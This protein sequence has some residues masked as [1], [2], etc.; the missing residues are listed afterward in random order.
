MSEFHYALGLDIGIGSVGWA[1]LRNQPNGEPDRIQDLG[2]RIFDKAEQPKTGASLAAP[3]RDARSAR[4]RL[5]R[6]RH[7]LERI[8]YLMEQRGIMPVADI[9]AMYA[10]G[11]FQ[12]SPYQLRAEALD[13]PLTKEEAV[14]VLIHLAQRRGYKSNSTAEAAKDEKE[15]GKVKTAIEENRRCMA[16]HGYRTVGE[17]MYRDE[18]FWQKHPDGTRYHQ[19]RN[20]AEDY[21]FTVERAAIVDEVRQIFAAQRRLGTAWMDEYMETAYLSIL[22]SQRSFDEGPGGD[23]PFSGGI[24]ERVGACTFEPDEKRAAKATY[25]FEYFKL[26][27]DLSRMRLTGM[28][29]PPEPLDAAQREVLK[30][31]A[32]RSASLSYGQ[33]RK[34]LNLDDDVFFHGLYYGEKTKEEAEKRKWPQMQSYHKMRTALDKVGKG[35]IGTLTEEQLNA[36][37]TILTECKSDAKRIAALREAGIPPQFDEALLPLSFSKYGSLSVQAMQK[38]IPLLEEGLRY[39]EACT[40]VYGDHRGLHPEQR[41]NRLSL[42]DMDEITNPV[43]RRAVSQTIKVINAVVRTYGPPDVVRIELAREMSRTFDERRKMEKRQDDNRAANERAKDQI[44]EYKGDHAT[45]LDIVKFKLYREQD[46]VCLYSGQ[47]LDIARLFEPGYADV[48]HIIPYSRCFDDSY[49]N[50]VLVLASENRQKGNRLPYEYFGQDEARWHGYEVRVE[51]LIHNYRKRQKLLKR[52]LT[53]E[54]SSGFIDRNLKDTQ[55]I[56]RAVY[57]LIRDHLAFAESNY[58]KKPVQ[59]V[60]GA[61]TAMLRGRWGVQKIREDGDLL[62]CSGQLIGGNYTIAGNVSSQYISGLLMA[63]PLLI[64][65]SLLMVSGPLE[66]A[67]YV[68]MTEDALQLSKLTIPKMGAMW[69]IP[70]QQRCH[71]PKRT[72]VEGDWSNTAFFLCMGALSK[73][74]VTVEGLNLQSSQGDRGVLDVLRRFGA[75]VTEHGDAVTVRRG[76]LHGVTI[77]AAPI[78]DLIPVLSVVASVAEGETRVE[79]ASRLRLKESD[80]LKSTADLLRAL[81]G[82]VE[83]KE[84]GLVITGVPALHGGAVETQNDHRL[85]MSAATAACAATGEI[86]VD[87]DGCV[88]KSYPCFWED[89]SS[90]K[91]EGL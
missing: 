36:V 50:K 76:T 56:T 67:A 74:G 31:A 41:K 32:L 28:G 9:Q 11:G 16:E 10:A 66:S 29:M 22:E 15:T 47:N 40:R 52:R 19:T 70:G 26:L 64:R 30:S 18:R 4:R 13:R 25:T 51:N 46:G 82:R 48:D 1:V 5:R 39:D 68:A 55:Y 87:N 43:V 65:D 75:E 78:P 59:A 85:A 49:Q 23:S 89:F 62:Y 61:V 69:A 27:Q 6:H 77:D 45:G 90:L 7:R 84:D 86:T 3:R 80:R 12:K 2:V 60:N 53:E 73:E 63:L 37:A 24:G 88:A 35:A 83:E 42:T 81:G 58:R 34:K 44:A 54:E 38:L 71:L 14:R 17:M 21:R 57:N 33:I 72:V 91:G 20:K 8:R 79:N